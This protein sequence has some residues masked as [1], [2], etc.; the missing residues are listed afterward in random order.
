MRT[1]TNKFFK[2]K[3]L[4]FVLAIALM[5]TS[6]YSFDVFS[7][8]KTTSVKMTSPATHTLYLVKGEKFKLKTKI[9]PKGNKVTY[10]SSKKSVV[11][12][13]ADGT[14]KAI[15]IGSAK[16]TVVSKDNSKKKDYVN[17][18]VIKKLQ[19]VKRIALNKSKATLYIDGTSSQ[20]K[21][22]LNASYTPKKPTVKKVDYISSNGKVATVSAKGLVTAKAVG[23][24]TITAYASDGRGAKATCVV[25]V[26]KKQTNTAA[27]TTQPTDSPEALMGN[28][29]KF[30][31]ADNYRS[32]ASVNIPLPNGVKASDITSISFRVD[33]A[34]ALSFRL[35]A[36]VD[37]VEKA[38]ANEL[39]SETAQIVKKAAKTEKVME[40]GRSVTKTTYNLSSTV[41]KTTRVAKPAANN[42]KVTFTVDSRAK[43]LL[44][45]VS[46][47]T[48]ALGIYAHN[49]APSY[50][51]YNLKITT[52]SGT[53]LIDL[54]KDNTSALA[55]G[56][57]T[58][59]K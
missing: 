13:T 59:T 52:A 8:S 10:K 11:K 45:K 31:S 33:T 37:S 16:I 51:F 43:A 4:L 39:T 12:V 14:L 47:N 57:V 3:C 19:K 27:P 17:V 28:M 15:K 55:G 40:D 56:K 50:S 38:A 22:A 2:N 48:L 46:G 9:L 29:A 42:Q 6:S 53:Y 41:T 25:T 30:S 32:Y 21:V 44:G 24:T 49:V 35:Y 54:T 20:K 34:K 36:G 58:I 23:K 5:L 26:A 18:K 1:I 7:K